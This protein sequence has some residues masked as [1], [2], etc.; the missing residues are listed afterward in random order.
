MLGLKHKGHLGIGA[1]GDVAIYTPNAN[2]LDM[3]ALAALTC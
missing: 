1:D 2:K 3:F